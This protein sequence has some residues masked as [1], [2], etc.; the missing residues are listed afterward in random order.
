MAVTTDGHLWHVPTV[1][2]KFPTSSQGFPA[3]G[4]Q[5]GDDVS[6]CCEI[7]DDLAFGA[8]LERSV[9]RPSASCGR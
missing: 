4:P 7:E 9:D 8:P 2:R 3:V 6:P 1:A 5:C